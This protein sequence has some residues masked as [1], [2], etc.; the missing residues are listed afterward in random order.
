MCDFLWSP[1]YECCLKL[2]ALCCFIM[3]CHWNYVNL[4]KSAHLNLLA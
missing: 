3:L 1:A 2:D 4:A